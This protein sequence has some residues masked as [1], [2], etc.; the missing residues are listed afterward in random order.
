M[1]GNTMPRVSVIIPT[2]NCARFLGRAIRTALSQTYTDHEVIVVD[3]G[4]TDETQE[5]VAPVGRKIHYL[6]QT[7]RGASSA[8]NLALSQANGEL[9]AYLDADDMWYPRK[10]ERQVAFLDTHKECALV[11]SDMTIIDELDKVIHFQFNQ[12]TKREVPHGYCALNLLRRGNIQ[13]ST[14][15]ERRGSNG[16]TDI[17]DER[18]PVCQDYLRWILVAMEGSAFGYIDEALAMYRWRTGSLFNS[19]QARVCE[20]LRKIFK[21]LLDEKS[22]E[23][24]FGPEAVEIIREH[25]HTVGRDLAYLHRIEGRPGSSMRYLSELIWKRPFRIELYVDL[26][27]AC[28]PAPLAAKLRMLKAQLS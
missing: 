2:F 28:V 7:N 6:Y 19:S 16:R 23:L 22:L 21:I 9:I 11:H 26:L 27:K 20:D 5:V 17:F 24:R 8:R 25:Q 10:L 15:V 12:V 3:D 14:V 4:S 1:K 18:L 13:T